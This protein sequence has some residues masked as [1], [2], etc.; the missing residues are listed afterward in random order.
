[1]LNVIFTRGWLG[2]VFA[3]CIPCRGERPPHKNTHSVNEAQNTLSVSSAEKWDP[4][5]KIDSLCR[6][7]FKYTDCIPYRRLRPQWHKNPF[8]ASASVWEFCGVY[9]ITPSFIL[10]QSSIFGSNRFW[11][12][13]V[14]DGNIIYHFIEYHY[15]AYNFIEYH[16]I[17]YHMEYY[18][19]EYHYII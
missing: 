6:W 11:K 2:L 1:M 18:N 14:F 8:V 19:I 5:Q 7:G 17:E 13:F 12:L 4:Q 16:Y 15:I 3:D 9:G 10:I